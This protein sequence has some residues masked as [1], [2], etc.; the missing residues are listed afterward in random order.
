MRVCSSAEADAELKAFREMD[1]AVGLAL[2]ATLEML[3]IE[4]SEFEGSDGLSIARVQGLF[5]KGIRLY[6]VKYE[7]YFHGIRILFLRL[8]PDRCV[9]V[10]GIH[11][12]GDLGPGKEYRFSLEPFR[13]A[14]IH[15]GMKE[16]LCH[17]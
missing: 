17:G 8:P 6:R 12:R 11:G 15:W 10:T 2:E 13:R 14:Q 16:H 1:A 7:R 3:E 9:Y 5:R 4:N